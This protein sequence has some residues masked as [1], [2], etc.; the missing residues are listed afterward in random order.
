MDFYVLPVHAA[1]AL[2]VS[3]GQLGLP[4]CG[5]GVS[6]DALWIDPRFSL[7]SSASEKS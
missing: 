2:G 3:V 4:R 1:Q 5:Y 6:G 7:K